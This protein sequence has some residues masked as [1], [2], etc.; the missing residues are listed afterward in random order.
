[1]MWIIGLKNGAKYYVLGTQKTAKF[2][3]L[4][5]LEGFKEINVVP[6]IKVG[7]ERKAEKLKKF[8]LKTEA[9]KNRTIKY[10]IKG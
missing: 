5:M 2:I 7:F 9:C 6:L 10:R 8:L 3:S 1:M 4:L